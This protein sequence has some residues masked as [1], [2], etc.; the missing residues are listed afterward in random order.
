[1]TVVKLIAWHVQPLSFSS[2]IPFKTV[3]ESIPELVQVVYAL[4]NQTVSHY[5]PVEQEEV[6]MEKPTTADGI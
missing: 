5:E 2:S 6:C 1:M 4:G 3:E